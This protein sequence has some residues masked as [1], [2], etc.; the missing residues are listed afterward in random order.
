MRFTP[1]T[2]P[3]LKYILCYI[4]NHFEPTLG[5]SQRHDSNN[6]LSVKQSKTVSR[7][8]WVCVYTLKWADSLIIHSDL[9]IVC[10]VTAVTTGAQVFP[11]F[12]A[13]R[14]LPRVHRHIPL[15]SFF[16]G[17]AVPS[18]AIPRFN[19]IITLKAPGWLS[20]DI[21]MHHLKHQFFFAMWWSLFHMKPVS[22]PI[23]AVL[24][25]PGPF[26]ISWNRQ[27]SSFLTTTY[28]SLLQSVH[29]DCAAVR[30]WDPHYIR[31]FP[32]CQTKAGISSDPRVCPT[33]HLTWTF[34]ETNNYDPKYQL[35]TVVSP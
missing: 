35:I 16:G 24:N 14:F 22:P 2:P 4:S 18:K 8:C 7:P 6:T 12:M 25:L 27:W 13:L 31:L 20:L 17:F 32:L 28:N 11:L 5:H 26:S 9:V 34:F 10:S 29:E 1:T 30:G 15:L 21:K 23:L 33:L 19:L 3:R